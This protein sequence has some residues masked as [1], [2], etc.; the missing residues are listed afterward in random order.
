MVAPGGT[1]EQVE[2]WS[3]HRNVQPAELTDDSIDAVI[4]PFLRQGVS[5]N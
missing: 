5:A 2:H 3:L 1:V 4:L